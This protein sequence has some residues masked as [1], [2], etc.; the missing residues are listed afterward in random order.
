[1][2][3]GVARAPAASTEM[4]IA[5]PAIDELVIRWSGGHRSRYRWRWLRDCCPCDHCV[6]DGSGQRLADLRRLPSEPRAVSSAITGGRLLVRWDD[7]DH[8]SRFDLDWLA[9]RCCCSSHLD[10]RA[11]GRRAP[12]GGTR[13]PEVA[14][15]SVVA[16]SDRALAWWLEAVAADGWARLRGVPAGQLSAVVD[17]FGYIRETNYGRVFDV[18]AEVDPANLAF[19]GLALGPHTDNPYR[20][21]VPTLQLLHCLASSADGGQSIM[22]D[23]FAAA[24]V[25]RTERPEAFAQLAT[26]PVPWRYADG[27]VDLATEAPVIELGSGGTM[28][29]IR[30]NERS[31]GPLRLDPDV[32]DDH[33]LALRRFASILDRPELQVRTTLAPGDLLLFDNRRMLHGRTAYS[34]TGGRHLQ[35]CYADRDGLD[36]KLAV[37]RRH[38]LEP[39]HD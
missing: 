11:G 4:P 18:R 24:A 29:A 17:R 34:S 19:T 13:C 39:H 14:D 33:L 35:G 16:S 36:S 30:F 27:S 6:G 1:M 9:A 31:R 22:V 38:I 2:H 8:V 21:P 25:L 26:W 15:W 37:L 7:D 23:G 5:V 32:V 10:D 12:A 28:V 3:I 20:R